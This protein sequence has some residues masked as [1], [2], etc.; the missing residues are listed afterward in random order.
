MSIVLPAAT[1]YETSR[2]LFKPSA[3]MATCI[4]IARICKF[5]FLLS[6]LLALTAL[7]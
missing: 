4:T 3:D 2:M 7:I 1:K 5:Y 6:F